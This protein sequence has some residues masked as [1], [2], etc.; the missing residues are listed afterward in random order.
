MLRESSLPSGRAPT[1]PPL[2]GSGQPH[3]GLRWNTSWWPQRQDSKWHSART[4][5]D[6]PA[7]HRRPLALRL[8]S[9]AA[10]AQ[11]RP[12]DPDRLAR[13]ARTARGAQAAQG[14]TAAPLSRRAPA[15]SASAA[16]KAAGAAQRGWGQNRCAGGGRCLALLR[17]ARA[18]PPRGS[19]RSPGPARA[20]GGAAAAAATRAGRRRRGNPPTARAA[21]PRAQEAR[22]ALGPW[23]LV[24]RLASARDE[25][26]GRC[27]RGCCCCR[28]YRCC[29]VGGCAPRPRPPLGRRPRTA[30]PWR[31]S[32]LRRRRRRATGKTA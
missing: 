8:G 14:P 20:G 24:T 12:R 26:P 15:Q 21:G 10:T 18:P 5:A 31:S 30:A 22:A 23:S 29:W 3:T 32:P 25:R 1:T 7:R 27:H 28:C 11:E 19:R 6:A 9:V 13:Y 4:Q 2:L 17:T 16:G